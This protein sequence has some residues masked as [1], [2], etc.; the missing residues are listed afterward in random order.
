MPQWC[1]LHYY[2]PYRVC[3]PCMAICS[4]IVQSIIIDMVCITKENK[5]GV[6]LFLN[7][8][9]LARKECTFTTWICDY[10]AWLLTIGII[11]LR[12]EPSFQ[13][14]IYIPVSSIQQRPLFLKMHWS[15]VA[16]GHR[17]TKSRILSWSSNS[18]YH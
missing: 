12:Y 5:M 3:L 2:M 9:L 13:L 14:N 11:L 10:S 6:I 8:D 16:P 1:L 7:I 18:I 15:W 4:W 17:A